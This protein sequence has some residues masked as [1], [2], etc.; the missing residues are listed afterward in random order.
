MHEGQIWAESEGSGLGSSFRVKLPLATAGEAAAP[1]EPVR[2]RIA[3]RIQPLKILL[4]EDSRDVMFLMTLELERLGYS[5]LSALDGEAGLKLVERERPDLIVSDIK[6]PGLDGYELIRRVRA[7][8]ALACTPAIAL[9][10]SGMKADIERALT[11]GRNACISRPPDA[12]ELLALIRR[13]TEEAPK[14]QSVSSGSH[15]G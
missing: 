3:T 14:P 10:G 6:M 4:I 1:A 13:F 5:V 7:T 8:E 15:N 11:A 9:T 2:P 12:Q